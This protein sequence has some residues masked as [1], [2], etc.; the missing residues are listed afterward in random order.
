MEEINKNTEAPAEEEELRPRRYTKEQNAL[1]TIISIGLFFLL[2]F[3]VKGITA[4][5]S[6]PYY[7]LADIPAI[8]EELTAD[9]FEISGISADMRGQGCTLESA[10]LDKN[11]GGYV[12][13]MVF[14]GIGDEEEFI[15]SGITFEYGNIEEDIRAEFCPAPENPAYVEY[16]YADKLVD[17]EAP[18]RELYLFEWNDGHYAEY[19]EYSASVPA[20]VLA[21]FSGQEKIYTNS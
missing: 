15:E 1:Y 4:A 6:R 3:G 16:V 14:S 10:R 17:I 11:S 21:I 7:I 8:G 20:E 12:L 5:A 19:R 9:A 18:S 2:Y 13:E